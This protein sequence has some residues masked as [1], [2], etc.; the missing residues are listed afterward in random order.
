MKRISET[1]ERILRPAERYLSTIINKDKRIERPSFDIFSPAFIFPLAVFAFMIL[2]IEGMTF[3]SFGLFCL[4]LS[5]FI[6]GYRLARPAG[7]ERF[8]LVWRLG[9]PLIAFGAIAE[10]INITYIGAVPLFMPAMRTKLLPLLTYASFLIVPGCI[11]KIS[12]SL[13]NDSRRGALFWLL[14]GLALI[15]LLGYRTEIYAL[16]LG[17][18]VSAYYIK[19]PGVNWKRAGKYAAALG[20]IA[21]LANLAVVSYREMPLSSFMG[22]F[23]LTTRVFSAISSEMGLSPFGVGGGAAHTSI[24]SSLKII[25]GP[26]IGPRTFISQLFGITE[27]ST[28]PTIIGLPF[29]DFGIAGIVIVGLILGLL[30]GAGHKTLLRGSVDIVPVHALLMAFLLLSI[31]TG[32]ADLIVILYLICYLVMVI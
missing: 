24:I 18:A 9:L 27:G 6:I 2:G 4:F 20:V 14:S 8:P 25:P 5:V 30:Y 28:T 11:I 29:V 10:F 13:L 15:S 32:I 17:A 3:Y 22:R 1:L 31:E 16:L 21:L 19:G 12:D 26:R 7:N 23:A